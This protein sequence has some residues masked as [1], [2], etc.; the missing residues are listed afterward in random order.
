M[1]EAIKIL[2]YIHAFFG[3][4]GLL[5]G[6]GSVATRK[7][8]ATHKKMGRLFSIGMVSSALI[9][10]PISWMPN[11]TN[12]FLFLMGLFTIYL[13]ISGNRALKYVREVKAERMDLMISGSMFVFS[14]I[15]LFIGTYSLL[16]QWNSGILYLVFG[17]FGLFLTLIDFRF[18]RNKTKKKN[19]YL[20]V[21][22]RKMS[23][24]FIAS[25]TAFLVAGIGLKS[26]M[27]WLLPS[28]LGTIYITYWR[29][30]VQ[31]KAM[32]K[33]LKLK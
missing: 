18:Y 12:V 25:I 14:C 26:L 28:I 4:I 33:T 11:H 21:H 29:L 32:V 3:G 6:L 19:A 5:A 15:M 16:K 31:G 8:S 20:V 9:S 7:G 13:V 10:M 24:A 2:I 22:I 30:K 23:G 1:E 17:G 27:F